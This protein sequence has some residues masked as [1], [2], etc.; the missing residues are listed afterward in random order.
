MEGGRWELRLVCSSARM[1]VRRE[2]EDEGEVEVSSTFH[3]HEIQEYCLPNREN[4]LFRSA[5]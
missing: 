4:Q 1:P 3:A 5:V 2:G